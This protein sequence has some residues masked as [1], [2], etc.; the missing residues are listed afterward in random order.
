MSEILTIEE[1]EQ[2]YRGEWVLVAYSET[3]EDL[4]TIAG[5]VIAHSAKKEEIYQALESAEEQ[6]LAIEYM[7]QVPEDLA[8]IL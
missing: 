6:S 3:D 2:K 5:K 4:E 8:Y 7:G 1:I